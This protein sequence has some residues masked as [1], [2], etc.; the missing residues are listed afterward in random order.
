MLFAK[1]DSLGTPLTPELQCELDFQLILLMVFESVTGMS[2][3][4]GSAADSLCHPVS[5]RPASCQTVAG[6]KQACLGTLLVMIFI[7]F[8]IFV[9]EANLQ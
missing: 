7:F 3:H 1:R 8:I 4:L 6:V 9:F 2:S 5:P